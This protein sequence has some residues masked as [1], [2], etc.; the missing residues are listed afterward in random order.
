MLGV[1]S[2]LRAT[3]SLSHL[4]SQNAHINTNV[5]TKKKILTKPI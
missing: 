1:F 4:P 5:K 3:H 2:I